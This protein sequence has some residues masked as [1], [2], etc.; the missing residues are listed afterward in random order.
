MA[1]SV[2]PKVS[3]VERSRQYIADMVSDIERSLT[4]QTPEEAIASMALQIFE[5]EDFAGMFEGNSINPRADLMDVGLRVESVSWNKSDYGE[6]LPFYA[7]FHGTI[8]EGPHKDTEFVTNCGG[9]QTVVVAYQC[10]KKYGLPKE[11]V[12]H[13]ADKPTSRGFYPVNLLPY[14]WNKDE[15]PF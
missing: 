6:G 1:K 12:F 13:K 7:T 4:S 8:L 11:F 15:Q 3:S 10:V 14:G 2:E 9:W 5:A